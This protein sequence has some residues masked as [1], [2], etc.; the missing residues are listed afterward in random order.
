MENE[1]FT[2][3]LGTYNAEPWIEQCLMSL[4]SQNCE[5]FSV[6]IIDNCSTDN[7][8]SIIQN[9]FRKH[10]FKN[11]YEL[12]KNDENV[13]AIST[14][15]DKLEIFH[16][17]WIFM[18]HQD[19]YYHPNHFST[20]IDQIN[21][22]DSNVSTVF[23]A[24]KRM[25][26][27]NIEILNPPTLAAKLSNNRFENFLL[28]VQI[29]PVNFPSCALR[30]SFLVDAETTK[31]TTAF[32]D[33]EMLIRM[34]CVS[35]FIYVPIETMHYRIH[36]GNAM[37][38]TNHISNDR[39]TLIGLNEIYHSDAFKKLLAEVDSD[40]KIERLVTATRNAVEIRILDSNLKLL[41]H[42]LLSEAL[43]RHTGY[44]NKAVVKYLNDSLAAHGLNSEQKIV[45]ALNKNAHFN[46]ISLNNL[47]A[48]LLI[49]DPL[50]SNLEVS[51]GNFWAK[52]SNI[53][54]IKFREKVFTLL[55]GSIL[56][57]F[58]KRPFIQ[59]WRMQNQND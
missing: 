5:P 14:F 29:N 15:L 40:E 1:L 17:E 43:V 9:L 52:L 32:N 12:I 7:T 45:N 26:Q 34:M 21:Q 35:D 37:T 54:G 58:S 41:A 4:E 49:R 38:I 22:V 10:S 18:V 44:K 55:F 23:T 36:S 51:S 57:K 3:F 53:F 42:T 47:D 19:D 8:I 31:H 24:M 11:S 59:V 30:K 46:T 25:D 56:F 50:V 39:A 33:N 27:N 20:L 16:S 13:G 2:V 6:K 28:A 48:E